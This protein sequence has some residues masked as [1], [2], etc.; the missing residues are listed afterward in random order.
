MLA[1]ENQFDNLGPLAAKVKK[2]PENRFDI[3]V[4]TRDTNHF[5]ARVRSLMVAVKR[6]ADREQQALALGED[7][8]QGTRKRRRKEP[9]TSPGNQSPR[10]A[11]AGIEVEDAMPAEN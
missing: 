6:E 11:E 1:Y 2:L 10:A 8:I 5:T 9:G 7:L 3:L 4:Q